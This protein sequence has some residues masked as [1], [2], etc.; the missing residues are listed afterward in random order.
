M[1]HGY[2]HVHPWSPL[3]PLRRVSSESP[4]TPT[5][6]FCSGV[7]WPITVGAPSHERSR[8]ILLCWAGSLQD[9]KGVLSPNRSKTL[10]YHVSISIGCWLSLSLKWTFLRP[11]PKWS[12]FVWKFGKALHFCVRGNGGVTEAMCTDKPWATEKLGWGKFTSLKY[13]CELCSPCAYP[14]I[15]S[16]CLESVRVCVLYVVL[17]C[18]HL[19]TV[20]F[21]CAHLVPERA[22]PWASCRC[23]GRP[24]G[25]FLGNGPCK[26]DWILD[27]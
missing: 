13:M 10:K 27:L 1:A 21:T 24:Q 18:T 11:C 19:H 7:T 8:G 5:P 26:V 12:V 16:L 6:G 23:L 9:C 15:N 2:A 17:Q 25:K 3:L 4:L 14:P 20:T 22:E